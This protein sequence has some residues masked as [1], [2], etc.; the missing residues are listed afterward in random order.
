ML[1]DEIVHFLL[2]I[3]AGAV[4][5]YFT[6]NWWAIPIALISG[7]LV[8]VD[9]LFDY[10]KFVRFRRFDLKEFTAAKYFDYSGKVYLPLHVFELAITLAIIG[11]F[12]AIHWLFYSLTLSLIF[13]LIFDTI[14]N[15]PIWPTYFLT[16]RIAKNFNYKSFDFKCQ[17]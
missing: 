10:F 1:K 9:H 14:S 15:K 6:H 16:F 8:D 4:V 5:G 2:S 7:V 11:Y 3:I 12:T 13:H 17:R